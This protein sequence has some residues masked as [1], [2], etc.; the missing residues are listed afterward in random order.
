MLYCQRPIGALETPNALMMRTC[1]SVASHPRPQLRCHVRDPLA[2]RSQL[3]ESSHRPDRPEYPQCP[4]TG[5]ETWTKWFGKSTNKSLSNAIICKA[6]ELGCRASLVLPTLELS[7]ACSRS[8]QRF[9]PSSISENRMV[10]S[11]ARVRPAT[12][13]S[14]QSDVTSVTKISR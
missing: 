3:L 12:T 6:L 2:V 5:L 14:Q 4:T 10:L 7:R 13:R 11:N 9:L 1:L 8:C